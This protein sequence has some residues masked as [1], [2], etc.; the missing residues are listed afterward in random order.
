MSEALFQMEKN[1]FI[2][3]LVKM[4]LAKK[5]EWKINKTRFLNKCYKN[6][7]NLVFNKENRQLIHSNKRRD[8]RLQ[9][10]GSGSLWKFF[11]K[12]FNFLWLLLCPSADI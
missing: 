9:M 5:R 11:P 6:A 3:R 1:K 8:K 2:F 4:I 12:C 10:L 7:Q